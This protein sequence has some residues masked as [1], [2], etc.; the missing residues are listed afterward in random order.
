MT[1]IANYI[2]T[3]LAT[4]LCV[5]LFAAGHGWTQTPASPK[6]QPPSQPPSPPQQQLHTLA[7]IIQIMKD[8]KLL[9]DFGAI[10]DSVASEKNEQRRPV[11]RSRQHI[12]K[13]N[14][15]P[16][17]VEYTV[18]PEVQQQLDLLNESNLAK[19]YS[20]SLGFSRKMVELDS[21]FN[22]ARTLIGDAFYLLQE[23]DSAIYWL[24][25]STK[26]NFADYE[27]HWFLADA[28]LA[29]HDTAGA[30]REL[31]LAHVLNVNANLLTQSLG[32]YRKLKGRELS[33]WEFRPYVSIHQT[34][35]TVFARYSARGEGY[36]LV[37][38]VWQYEP[39]YAEKMLGRKP[40]QVSFRMLEEREAVQCARETDSLLNK[41][42]IKIERA[43]YFEEF[44]L[45]EIAAKRFPEW[46]PTLPRNIINRIVE[47]V[48]KF[49]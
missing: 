42:L 45:Y 7:E 41:K 9:Y 11:L 8:S 48:D 18:T 28:M 49:R 22:P 35:D 23:Y 15:R 36:A 3:I 19:N 40:D 34:G 5:L 14:G 13:V 20:L 46:I 4:G 43:G 44:L 1:T 25:E 29:K 27:A 24:R 16:T 6:K 39:G 21:S 38:A 2:R 37:K 47:Y 30:M 26:H 17:L 32:D 31:T 33:E 10:P 12:Q